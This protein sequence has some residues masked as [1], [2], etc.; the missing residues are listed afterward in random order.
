MP[1]AVT[2]ALDALEY[3]LS[4]IVIALLAAMVILIGSQVA[5]RYLVGMPLYW[6]EE[7]A[8]HLMIWLFF[9]GAVIALR[10]GAHLSIDL[11]PE[12]LPPPAALVMR[13]LVLVILG[14][15][16]AMMTWFGWDLAQRTMVQ[17][18]SALHYPMGYVYAALPV[19]GF[20]ML[21]V[22]LER[23]GA[24]IAAYRADRASAES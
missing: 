16:L 21:L 17:R 22:T 6:S 13:G 4:G 12:S 24:T 14:T 8:R 19:S 10:R 20:L 9:L 2:R 11:L 3:L 15:F 1:S 5:A 7:L 18:A 23:L